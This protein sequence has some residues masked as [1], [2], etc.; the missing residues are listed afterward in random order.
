MARC[1][2]QRGRRRHRPKDGSDTSSWTTN[3]G[4]SDDSGDSEPE[5]LQGLVQPQL[6][7]APSV[8]AA[9]VSAAASPQQQQDGPEQ[10]AL[11]GPR[12]Q[13]PG[14][15][16]ATRQ[17]PPCPYGAELLPAA[18]VQDP[19]QPVGAAEL[20]QAPLA[21]LGGPATARQEDGQPAAQPSASP[22]AAAEP[23]STKGVPRAVQGPGAPTVQSSPPQLD[24]YRYS[25]LYQP[26][27]PFA[28]MAQESWHARWVG[29]TPPS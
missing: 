7:S 2:A 5:D 29:P 11:E 17:T 15:A 20:P 18:V 13:Q 25:E 21:G 6:G 3:S 8:Q 10:P 26:A 19:Q 27:D 22:F 4:C 14:A 23:G 9:A 16:S 28:A 1:G 24:K 12:L